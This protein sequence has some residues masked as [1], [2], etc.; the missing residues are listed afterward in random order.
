MGVLKDHRKY[1]AMT[2][3]DADDLFLR[4][5]KVKADIDRKS[6]AHKKKIA[7]LEAAHKEQ[8]AAELAEKEALEKELGS[9]ILANPGRFLKPRNHQVGSVG[10]YGIT[11]DPAYVQIS[12]KEAFIQFALENGYEDLYRTEHTPDK[13]AAM[14]RIMA[15]EDIPGATLIPAGDVAKFSFKKGYAEQ[16]ESGGK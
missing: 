8:I 5:A 12:D 6:A 11:T 3:S 4:L 10:S 2:V 14:R 7:D 13:V 16:L 9:Y 1:Q 15:Q